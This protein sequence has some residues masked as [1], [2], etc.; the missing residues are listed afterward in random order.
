MNN[1]EIRNTPCKEKCGGNLFCQCE[2]DFAIEKSRQDA[3]EKFTKTEQFLI[4]KLQE[5]LGV[6]E[7]L[8]RN[9]NKVRTEHL[10][11]YRDELKYLNNLI[12][13]SLKELKS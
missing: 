9:N 4:M 13:D 3:E 8:A 10:R 12:E 2:F 5:S 11:F 7:G 6:I 1:E